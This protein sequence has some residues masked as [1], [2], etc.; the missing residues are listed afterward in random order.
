MAEQEDKKPWGDLRTKKGARKN[1]IYI[2]IYN[3]WLPSGG[4]PCNIESL[5]LHVVF[6]GCKKGTLQE[7]NISHLA[8]RKIIFKMDFSEDMLVLREGTHNQ[9]DSPTETSWMLAL[10]AATEVPQKTH[11]EITFT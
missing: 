8:K 5:V 2:Y 7:I 11:H 4:P 9:R 10:K 6:S 3:W 1:S